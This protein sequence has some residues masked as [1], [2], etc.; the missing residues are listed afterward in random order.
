MGG[1][2]LTVVGITTVVLCCHL[3]A[4]LR[5]KLRQSGGGIQP[6]TDRVRDSDTLVLFEL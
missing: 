4:L 5:D 2:Y 6:G 3:M 1:S